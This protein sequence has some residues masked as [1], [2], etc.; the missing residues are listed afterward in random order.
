MGSRDASDALQARYERDYKQYEQLPQP[1]ITAAEVHV[2]LAPET[3][4]MRAAIHR[5]QNA[6]VVARRHAPVRAADAVECRGQ[7]P[8]EGECQTRVSLVVVVVFVVVVARGFIQTI[9]IVL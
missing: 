3:G 1:R 2:D 9:K 4:H 6:D 8:S 7:S 5:S